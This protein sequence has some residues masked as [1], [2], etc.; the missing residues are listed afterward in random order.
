MPASRLGKH[1][2]N[3]GFGPSPSGKPAC[4]RRSRIVIHFN[5]LACR[6]ASDGVD[7]DAIF[8]RQRFRYRKI[9]NKR[10]LGWPASEP[11]AV[12]LSLRRI[13]AIVLASG[14]I[15]Y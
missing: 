1:L 6:S 14:D 7:G 4:R 2:F 10:R 3:T 13:N 5:L 12:E 11:S 15:A 8:A 9:S